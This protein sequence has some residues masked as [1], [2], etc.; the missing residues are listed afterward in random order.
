MKR[1]SSLGGVL[2][3]IVLGA[4]AC[5]GG[6]SEG[7]VRTK[8]RLD[9]AASSAPTVMVADSPLGKILVDADGHALYEFDQDTPMTP[10]CTGA[11]ASLW[12]ALIVSGTP[13]AGTGIDAEKLGV[14]AVTSGSEVTYA[15]H[16]LHTFANDHTPGDVTGQGFGGLWWVVGADGRKITTPTV[17]QA[18]T[19]VDAGDPTSRVRG[20]LAARDGATGDVAARA[21]THRSPEA[22]T[23]RHDVARYGRHRVLTQRGH[24]SGPAD[25]DDGTDRGVSVGRRSD[26][27]R[28]DRDSPP[29]GCASSTTGA[30]APSFTF[31]ESAGASRRSPS[32][33]WFRVRTLSRNCAGKMMVEFRSTA[34]SPSTWRLRSC[35]AIG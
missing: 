27:H 28:V 6:S 12:P 2:L 34:I 7:T 15:G 14:L 23:T 35:N 29:H 17:A 4:A 13:R 20:D 3:V 25:R 10:A 18:P 26:C 19:T 1:I 22:A 30:E 31:A 8:K 33:N 32:T 11:C 16:P 9:G 24:E 5:G 21:P